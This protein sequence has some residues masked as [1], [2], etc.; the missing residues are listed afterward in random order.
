MESKIK[1]KSI[2]PR[3]YKVLVRTMWLLIILF[4]L[5][6]CTNEKHSF[7][8]REGRQK[9]EFYNSVQHQGASQMKF[10]SSKDIKKN[11]KN[12][13]KHSQNR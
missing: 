4:T 5:T 3:L 1:P 6:T 2:A 11:K 10:K 7:T 9:L 8:S 12:Q 13:R